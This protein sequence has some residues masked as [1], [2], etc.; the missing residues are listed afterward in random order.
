[1]NNFS[2]NYKISIIA[3]FGGLLFG[4]DTAVING[5]LPFLAIHFSVSTDS[6]L[7]SQIASSVIIGCIVG[8]LFAGKIA[9]S[10]GRRFSLFLAVSLYIISAVGSAFCWSSASLVIFRIVGGF[11]VGISSIVSPMFISEVSPTH[12]RGRLVSLN[13]LSIMV[14][15]FIS[16]LVNYLLVNFSNNWRLMLGVELIP[17]SLFLFGLFFIP[18]SPRWLYLKNRKEKAGSVFRSLNIEYNESIDAMN[19]SEVSIINSRYLKVLMIGILLC[20]FQQLTGYDII[21]YYSSVIFSKI[22]FSNEDALFQGVLIGLINIIFTLLSMKY[23]DRWGRKPIALLG[24]F[25]MFISLLVMSFSMNN[26]FSI[27]TICFML[28][29]VASFSFS[30]GPVVWV[31]V[32]EIFPDSIR[33]IGVSICVFFMWLSG[34]ILVSTFPILTD[35]FREQGTVFLVYAFIS[36]LNI[37]FIWT[38]VSETKGL[39]LE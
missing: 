4:Y 30:L 37:I 35:Y 7:I 20:C 31:M 27:I 33:A 17:C 11:G 23:I 25:L 10:L 16:L 38:S 8:S 5:A 36:F 18:E 39:Q 32:S 9:D 15:I 3:A 12:I 21:L 22:G 29:Y 24:S 1:M 13:Q 2:K 34:Y 19:K 14:G 28:L 6:L 26:E